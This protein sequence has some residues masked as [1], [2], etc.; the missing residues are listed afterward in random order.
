MKI[1]HDQKRKI[2]TGGW[3]LRVWE[4]FA[5]VGRNG[6]VSGVVRHNAKDKMTCRTRLN[7]VYHQDIFAKADLQSNCNIRSIDEN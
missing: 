2:F 6:R 4:K 7:L 3:H 5:I 1:F